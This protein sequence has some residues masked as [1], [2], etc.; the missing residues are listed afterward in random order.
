[1]L[2]WI[3]YILKK[4]LI[5]RRERNT[6][7]VDGGVAS[8]EWWGGENQRNLYAF[9]L[10]LGCKQSKGKNSHNTTHINWKKSDQKVN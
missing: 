3:L 7:D 6:L 5:E 2:V 9:A 8:Q 1:M 10:T 4:W